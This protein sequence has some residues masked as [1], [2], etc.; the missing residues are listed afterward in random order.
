VKNLKVYE[1]SIL[2]FNNIDMIKYKICNDCKE[3]SEKH[4]DCLLT[5]SVNT[6][7]HIIENAKFSITNEDKYKNGLMTAFISVI[8]GLPI[9][10]AQDHSV[11]RLENILRN[12]NKQHTVQGLLMPTNACELFD[13]PLFLIRGL[14]SK[15]CKANSYTPFV[16]TYQVK[17]V[18]EWI[19][20]NHRDRE[21]LLHQ[22]ISEFC[23]KNNILEYEYKLIG[24]TRIEFS[25]D[26][27]LYP[28]LASL[29]FNMEIYLCDEFKFSLEVMFVSK[30]DAN[31]KRN[32][33][34]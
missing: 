7:T 28:S 16:N 23:D 14:Y 10:E 12:K 24:D 9:L 1:E 8:I 13:I 4:N 15:Y 25:V 5:I 18:P 30:K 3:Y 20:T 26:K 21:I 19:K 29:L 6:D 34:S 31:R 11:L 27:D 33:K 22:K 17:E 32:K 2:L